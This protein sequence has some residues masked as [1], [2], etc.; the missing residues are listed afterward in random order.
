MLQQGAGQEQG[1]QVA[2]LLGLFIGPLETWL[3][4]R[5]DRRLVRT[6]LLTLVAMVRMRHNR[7]GLLLS[8]LGAHIISPDR[9]PAGTK[10]LSNLLRSSKWSHTL[11]EEFLWHDADRRLTELAAAGEGALAIW[12]ESVLEKPESIALEGLCP[13][14]SSKAARLKRIK[15]GY[16]NPPGGPPVFVPGMQW[17]TVIVAGMAGA[18]TLAAMGWWT[19]RGPLAS[20]RRAQ[21][22]T[23]LDQCAQRWQQRVIHL[24]DRGY[25]GAPWL[26]ELTQRQLCFI[27]RWPTRHRLVDALGQERFPGQISRGKRSQDHRM[28]WDYNRRQYRKTGILTVPVHHPQL[29]HPLWLVVSRPGTGRTP[30]YLL[31][32]QPIA[33]V[34]DAWRVVMAYARRWQVEMCYRACKTDLAMESPRLWF[35]ENRLKLLLMA[36]LVYA[37]LLHLLTPSRQSLVQSLIRNWCHRTG[38][39]YR[40]A[41]LPLPRLRSAL[42]T[43]W[44]THPPS[45]PHL[46][47]N[48][49]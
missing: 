38:E 14:R 39:R 32:N 23:L 30:W 2:D 36:S 7:Y 24:F 40:Q 28:I 33:S 26:E 29:D 19:S 27:M 45:F 9:A 31:T 17:L 44:L 10:R 15:P 47:P 34:D 16:Y 4:H 25:A 6:F 13:V 37:F 3:N 21:A 20:H 46:N 48:S 18:P 11:L 42:S 1:Q 5:L 49:G 41:K 8:E 22:A 43:L 35:W 12:D